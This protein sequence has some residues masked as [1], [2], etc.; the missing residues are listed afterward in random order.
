VSDDVRPLEMWTVYGPTTTDHPGMFVVR[1]FRI[2]LGAAVPDA[3]CKLALT[4]E[5]ARAEVPW[6]LFCLPRSPDDE[7]QIVET[8]I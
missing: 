2:T 3:E 5:E 1:R 8:W 6:G 4:L 7:P